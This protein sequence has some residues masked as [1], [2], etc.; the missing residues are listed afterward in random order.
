[1]VDTLG[2]KWFLDKSMSDYASRADHRGVQLFSTTVWHIEE[3]NG[4]RTNCVV[5][6]DKVIVES[7]NLDEIGQYIN[8]L[9]DL[10]FKGERVE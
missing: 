10:K 2:T 9:K 7:D 4:R 8:K 1:M 5:R 3:L 6:H